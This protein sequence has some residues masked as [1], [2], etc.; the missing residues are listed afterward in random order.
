MNN[1]DFSSVTEATGYNV[2]KEQIQRMYTRYRFAAELCA[3]KDILEVGCGTG[4]GLGLLAKKANYV[5]GGDIDEKMLLKAKTYYNGRHNIDFKTL[6]A[7]KLEF[8]DESFDIVILYEA[9]YYLSDPYKF[10]AEAKRVLRKNGSLIICSANSELPDFNPSPY[11]YQYFSA[12]ELAYL[13][14]KNGFKEIRLFGDCPIRSGSIIG[15][16][17]SIIKKVAVYFNMIPKTM[18]G[19]E[20]FKRIFL[21]KLSPL[22]PEIKET[23]AEYVRPVKIFPA[24][25]NKTYKVIFAI[26]YK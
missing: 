6:D 21:G 20:I 25:P 18:K 2:T 13:F 9:I 7:H 11:S 17:I 24:L 1:S 19:K 16:A 26:G 15:M 3:G 5:I 10:I 23:T 4:Q 14:E 22:P 8:D 12:K